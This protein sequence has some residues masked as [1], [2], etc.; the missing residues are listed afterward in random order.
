VDAERLFLNIVF[1]HR[2]LSDAWFKLGNIYYRSGRYKAS[3]NAYETVLKID[4]DYDKAWYNLGLAR[5]SQSIEVLDN[6]LQNISPSS[7]YYLRTVSLRNSLVRRSSNSMN[8][9]NEQDSKR[10]SSPVVPD[11]SSN[12]EKLNLTDTLSSVSQEIVSEG[13]E[14]GGQ[15]PKIEGDLKD[16]TDA[17]EGTNE[18]VI[19]GQPR[20]ERYYIGQ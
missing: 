3:V 15:T 2:G 1:K 13:G 18:K 9:P 14:D 16:G 5:L 4:N 17:L 11:V 12:K 8:R 6:A 10:S 19:D 7:P 20:G